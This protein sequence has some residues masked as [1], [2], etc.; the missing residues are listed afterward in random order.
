MSIASENVMRKR[1]KEV[2]GDG[3][4][5][6]KVALTFPLKDDKGGEEVLMKPFGYILDLW[7][8]VEELLEENE[9][10][11]VMSN[12][13]FI[14]NLAAHRHGRLT[15][16]EGRLPEDEIWVKI[17]GWHYENGIPNSERLAPQCNQQHMC[18]FLL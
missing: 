6:D 10:Y 16:H 13:I 8:K 1:A 15:W 14:S 17:G 3:A 18:V 12:S 5:V 2:I 7:K 11:M 4:M 9:R